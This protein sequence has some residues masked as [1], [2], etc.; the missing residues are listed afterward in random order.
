MSFVYRFLCPTCS[1]PNSKA[2]RFAAE[3]TCIHKAAKLGD[4]KAN[5]R[6]AS[7]KGRGSGYLWDKAEA[8]G[9]WGKVI[10]DK[11]KVK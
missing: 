8:W 11:K 10:G 3:K 5:L 7:R 4:R 1:K 6:S 9:A 2:L